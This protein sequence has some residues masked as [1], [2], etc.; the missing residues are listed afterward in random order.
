MSTDTYR[1]AIGGLVGRSAVVGQ[2]EL[3]EGRLARQHLV[4]ARTS[5]HLEEWLDGPPNLAADDPPVNLDAAD[6]RY[7]REVGLNKPGDDALGPSCAG[8]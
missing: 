8:Y 3:F 2:E 7:P 6:A 4:D 1:T 5:E